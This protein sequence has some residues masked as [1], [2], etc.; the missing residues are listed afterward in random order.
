VQ[1]AGAVAVFAQN[2]ASGVDS[3]GL[4]ESNSAGDIDGGERSLAQKIPMEASE[5]VPSVGPH[6][7]SLG[8]D[9][10]G[11]GAG[12]AGDVDGGETGLVCTSAADDANGKQ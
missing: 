5:V 1:A 10:I 11:E 12:S 7:V 9:P 3:M 4:S 6:D 2:I 8:V